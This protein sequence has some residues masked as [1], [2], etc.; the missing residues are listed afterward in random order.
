MFLLYY[1]GSVSSCSGTSYALN[2]VLNALTWL[3]HLIFTTHKV[4]AIIIHI[5]QIKKQI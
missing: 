5:L 4:G 3:S 1:S 2:A